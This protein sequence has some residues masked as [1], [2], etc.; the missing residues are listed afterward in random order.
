[1]R[2]ANIFTRTQKRFLFL[3]LILSAIF[4]LS[5]VAI[6]SMSGN[7]ENK[8]LRAA[9]H[10]MLS[11]ERLLQ[12]GLDVLSM[13]GL[14]EIQ[15]QKVTHITM[16]DWWMTMFTPDGMQSPDHPVFILS[17]KGNGIWNGFGGSRSPDPET[18]RFDSIT[19]ALDGV[20][21]NTI[22]VATGH[23]DALLAETTSEHRLLWDELVQ[24]PPKPLTSPDD[25]EPIYYEGNQGEGEGL[26]PLPPAP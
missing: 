5:S 17:V 14:E 6:N 21:G 24:N 2:H 9:D 8:E 20:T 23:S 18:R 15:E 10:V 25:D 12:I 16:Q 1:M 22:I 11:D 4:M 13:Y 19:V 7:T 3:L 26:I